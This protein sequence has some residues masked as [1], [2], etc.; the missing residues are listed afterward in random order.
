M[1]SSMSRK[2]L[3]QFQDWIRHD[4]FRS[5]DGSVDWRAGLSRLQ[6]PVL[7]MGGSVD[8][9]ATVENLHAQYALLTAPDRTLHVFGKDRGDRMD[10]GHGDLIFGAGAPR[11]VYPVIRAWLEAHATPWKG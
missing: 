3:L 11:E 2:V 7:V 9:L 10:Y 6:L 4:A 1:M 8:R 5:F